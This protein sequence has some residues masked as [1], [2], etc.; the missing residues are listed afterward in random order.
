MSEKR[1]FAASNTERGFLSY[2]SE[3]FRE[4]AERCYIIKGGPGTGKSRL[5]R[6]LAEA[7]EIAG[8]VV[9]Y[10]YCSSDPD[11]L[12]GIFAK[13]GVDSFAVLD[14]TAPHSEDLVSPGCIDNIIDLGQFWNSGSLRER[15]RE[16]GAL[17]EKK[18]KAY[19]SAYRAL[20]AYGALTR[21]ADALVCECVDTAAIAE[22]CAGIAV[23]LKPIPRLRTPLSAIGMKGIR[24]F[25][26]FAETARHTLYVTDVRGY[27][28]SHL[29]LDS[30]IRSVGPCMTAPDPIVADRYTAILTDG[31]AVVCS[32]VTEKGANAIDV[33]DFVDRSAYLMRRDRAE[34]LRSLAFGAL[35]E[36]K[37]SFSEAGDA[38]MKI[39][40]IFISAMDFAK[41]EAYSAEL[42]AKIAR[43]DL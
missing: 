23:N 28:C 32:T 6:E 21:L 20:S 40:E 27:G 34:H 37:I 17:V 36:A 38:H 30:L 19:P 22:E 4:R 35:D 2:F 5:M 33:S 7:A 14:G 3:I 43:G 29:Y 26:T 42:C 41:K 24:S 18:K 15:K 9:E 31:V 25:D 13:R 1:Y 11:S 10:Y 39:E 12:D 8:Y 16:I